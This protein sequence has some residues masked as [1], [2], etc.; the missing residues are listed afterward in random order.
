MLPRNP[1]RPNSLAHSLRVP[2]P[3]HSRLVPFPQAK[4]TQDAR[5]PCVCRFGAI[6]NGPQKPHAVSRPH[7]VSTS[8]FHCTSKREQVM[9][10]LSM[11][12]H[13]VH[14]EDYDILSTALRFSICR[15]IHH[16]SIFEQT[17]GKP[18]AATHLE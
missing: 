6:W 16:F 4:I 14:F 12:R 1:F 11:T 13:I 7:L 18:N 9:V 2:P 15:Q 5:W 3:T 10:Q 8:F 17:L